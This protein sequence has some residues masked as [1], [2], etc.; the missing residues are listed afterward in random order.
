MSDSATRLSAALADR[1]RVERE[2]GQGGM[3]TV[4]LAHDI[5]HDRDVVIKVLHPDLGAALGSEP[6]GPVFNPS[7]SRTLFSLAGYRRARNRQQYD[8]SPDGQRFLMIREQSGTA[9]RG[10]V[11]VENWLTELRAKV[12]Q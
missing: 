8:V 11:Y 6:P 9:N 3:A 12:K 7:N 10:V 1:Y 5:K 2:L 4:Y